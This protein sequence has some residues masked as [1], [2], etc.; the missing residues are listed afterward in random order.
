MVHANPDGVG[1][2]KTLPESFGREAILMRRD[3]TRQ[4]TAT[5]TCNSKGISSSARREPDL[6]I[7]VQPTPVSTK[8]GSLAHGVGLYRIGLV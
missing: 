1:N 6:L 3:L 7:A 4:Y 8:D 2:Q 5:L